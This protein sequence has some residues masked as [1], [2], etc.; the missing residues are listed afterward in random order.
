[1]EM[2]TMVRRVLKLS[3]K[4]NLPVDGQSSVTT[5][6]PEQQTQMLVCLHRHRRC[7]LTFGVFE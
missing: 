6:L 1:M 3:I 4:Q 7:E 2:A 5:R